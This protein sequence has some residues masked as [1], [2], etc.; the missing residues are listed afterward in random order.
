MRKIKLKLHLLFSVIFL[1]G[2]GYSAKA[3]DVPGERDTIPSK[4][5]GET[6][7]IRVILPDGYKQG[8]GVKYDVLYVLDAEDDARKI[9][10]I[11][12]FAE[13]YQFVPPM[14]IVNI[15]T[16][17]YNDRDR[18]FTPSH[19]D[20]LPTSGGAKNFLA[21]LKNEVIPF[22]N[23][24]YP[25][26][27]DN[28]LYGHSLGGLFTF[29]AI[30]HEPQLFRSYIINDPSLWWDNGYMNRVLAQNLSKIPLA[31][32]T[33]YIGSRVGADMVQ[34]GTDV[35]DR[36]FKASAPTGLIWKSE[37][38]INENH[39][40]LIYKVAY[41]GLKYT[42][43]GYNNG[44][45]EFHPM[46]GIVLK[47]K[48]FSLVFFNPLPEYP[49]I[50]YTT[51]GTVPTD[52]SP[53]ML[54]KNTISGSTTINIK[55]FSLRERYDTTLTAHYQTGQ[56]LKS[57]SQPKALQPGGLHYNYYEGVFD[58]LPDFSKLRPNKTGLADN[59]F[60]IAYNVA[61]LPNPN[62]FALLT[63]GFIEI[64][65]DGYYTFLLNS[66]DGSK[67]Y[68]GDKLLIDYDGMHGRWASKSYM[69]PLEKGFYPVRLEYFQ[70]KYDSFL[71][72]DWISPGGTRQTIIPFD[73]LYHRITK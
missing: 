58:K 39:F 34:M 64:K 52:N 17:Y 66:D 13:S 71:E 32:K 67:F 12:R 2:L 42:Y 26:D 43:T 53:K 62:N 48:P 70:N 22:V 36:T 29:Y 50:R 54:L 10:N 35:M 6:R 49:P 41:D 57:I 72:L 73:Q 14:I 56:I 18:D 45:M 68:L 28:T 21:F 7:D 44:N 65:E 38:Y 9:L 15:L 55:S 3:Q 33:I 59:N 27:G 47:D 20:S 1:T 25:T 31:G 11:E 5:L 51:D 69:V 16:I 19:I 63:E 61:K 40:S 4:I 30:L 46:D 24:K 37:H 8:S 60:R 23:K